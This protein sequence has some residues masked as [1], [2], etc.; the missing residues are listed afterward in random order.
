MVNDLWFLK[1]GFGISF[2]FQI[3]DENKVIRQNTLY[4]ISAKRLMSLFLSRLLLVALNLEGD[5][6]RVVP[7]TIYYLQ[8]CVEVFSVFSFSWILYN[9]F[10]T[11]LA[12]ICFNLYTRNFLTTIL[13]HVRGTQSV[14]YKKKILAEYPCWMFDWGL[15]TPLRWCILWNLK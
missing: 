15:D 13:Q 8:W 14:F 2:T 3:H 5:E 11:F 1:T 12:L 9:S 6:A 7:R 10:L 4:A